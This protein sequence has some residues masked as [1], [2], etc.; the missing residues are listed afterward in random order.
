MNTPDCWAWIDIRR[1]YRIARR[2][3]GTPRT[4]NNVLNWVRDYVQVK[5][6]GKITAETC[7]PR[8]GPARNRSTRLRRMGQT[9]PRNLHPQIQRW[10]C[11]SQ[12]ARSGGGRRT[13]TLEEVNEPYLIM[14]GYLHRTPQGRVATANAYRKLGLKPP[15][16]AQSELF[17]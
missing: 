13:G 7:R 1:C 12:L 17:G 2:C 16:G 6:E 8:A 5:A 15:A 4:A 3:R 10:A 9:H 11:W 14:E